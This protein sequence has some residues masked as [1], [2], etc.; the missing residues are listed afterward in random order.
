[1]KGP[2]FAPLLCALASVPGRRT[3]AQTQYGEWL[4]E[5]MAYSNCYQQYPWTLS[6]SIGVIRA[7]DAPFHRKLFATRLHVGPGAGALATVACSQEMLKSQCVLG[8][9]YLRLGPPAEE[10]GHGAGTNEDWQLCKLGEFNRS[11]LPVNARAKSIAGGRQPFLFA[12]VTGPVAA[13]SSVS[14]SPLVDGACLPILQN[15]KTKQKPH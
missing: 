15:N 2:L 4:Y 8:A 13:A 12:C 3:S 10:R 9:D 11:S 5:G 1:M 6:A 7:A 14:C